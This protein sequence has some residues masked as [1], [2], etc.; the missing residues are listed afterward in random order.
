M[1]GRIAA[2]RF[3]PAAAL[4]AA[5]AVAC[6]PPP[7]ENAA[8]LVQAGGETLQGSWDRGAGDHDQPAV[9][10]FKGIPYAAPP[11]GPLRWRPPQPAVPRTGL[12]TATAYGPGCYQAGGNVE[13]TRS[14]A[15]A[16]G[17]D[18]ALVPELGEISEDCLYLNVWTADPTAK[19][20]EKRPV[21]M[22]IYGG[23]NLSGT[24]HEIPY[25]GANLARKGAVVVS[26]NYRVNVFGFL[27]H[28][29]LSAEDENGSSG[30]YGLL[31][32]IAA[33][34]WTQDNIEAFGGDPQRV[35]IF[36]E[37][38]GGLNVTYLMASPLARG[39]FHRAISQ[40][41][42]YLEPD[43]RTLAQAETDGEA[44]I[45]ALAAGSDPAAW[46]ARKPA[47][48]LTAFH[49]A[50]AEIT[51][52]IGPNVDGWLLEDKATAVHARGEQ[53]DVPLIAGNN[54]DEWSLFRQYY[55]TPPADQLREEIEEALGDLAAAAE[56]F[57]GIHED[58]DVIQA[59]DL[60]NG[61]RWFFCAP[62]FLLN[63]HTPLTSPGYRYV[64]TR[65][66]PTAG[67]D[68]LGAWHGAEI[69]YVFDNLDDEV[70]IPR[71]PWD[72]E[73]AEKIS[74]Y[75]VSFATNGDPNVD[76]LPE[77]PAWEPAQEPF[78]ELGD[79]VQTGFGWRREACRLRARE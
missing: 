14:I 78:L 15:R 22:W 68:D 7:S 46:R 62:R 37:S 45:R 74:S 75:W 63:A 27:A 53:H 3:V 73:L 58:R 57:Y 49:E 43:H 34:R 71:Q 4:A 23:G 11:V 2:P 76:G 66:L 32:Q 35:T 47:D 13:Y 77:W 67:G 36:G 40:S 26:I 44:V 25:D 61:D 79:S 19:A 18:P 56:P 64:F 60:W 5:L 21:M 65:R 48:L 50:G 30:N 1:P 72:D 39:L 9:A 6:A 52:E 24:S 20:G 31:D 16:L 29:A 28:P 8:P 38:A 70:Y 54:A 51:N 69:G 59:N 55:P 10:V 42:G 12:Q 33:L 17:Q 41:G